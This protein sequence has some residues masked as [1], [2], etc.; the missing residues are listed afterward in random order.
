MLVIPL[1]AFND[2]F[3]T[4]R[5]RTAFVYVPNILYT[6][7]SDEYDIPVT[8]VVMKNNTILYVKETSKRII[9]LM[10][11]KREKQY[12]RIQSSHGCDCGLTNPSKHGKLDE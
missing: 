12:A 9:E 11:E 3:N 5:T 2:V 6:Y 4:E 10:N 7:P 8:A 1:K